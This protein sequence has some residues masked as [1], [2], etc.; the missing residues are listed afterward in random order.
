[1]REAVDF[2]WERLDGRP[3]VYGSMGT[4]QNGSERIFRMIAEACARLDVQAVLSLGGSRDPADLGELPGRPVVVRY[5]PQLELVK[6][7]AAVITHAG[8]NTTL[9]TLAEG[10]PL[11]AIPLGNDQPGV[12]ARIAYRGAGIVISQRRLSVGALQTAVGTVL[13]DE[14]YRTAA[15]EIQTAMQQ[16]DGPGAAAD[17]IESVL[18]LKGRA[19]FATSVE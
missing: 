6:R 14:R 11:V 19:D 7:A 15:R 4:L 5:A 2:P 18:C 10:V 13:R 16:I 3:L 8:L 1:V 17:V 12:A 9:E